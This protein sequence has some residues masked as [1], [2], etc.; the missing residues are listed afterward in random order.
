MSLRVVQGVLDGTIDCLVTD[1]APH[2]AEEKAAGFRKAPFGIVGLETIVALL[3]TDL[4]SAGSFDWAR[5]ISAL[6][7]KPLSVLGLPSPTLDRGQAADITLI[8][9]ACDWVIA[10]EQFRSKGRNTP[11][12]GSARCRSSGWNGAGRPVRAS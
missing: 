5:F 6:S 4:V 1:H 3:G 7:C 11:F 12:E 10:P 2:T 9:P 8:D